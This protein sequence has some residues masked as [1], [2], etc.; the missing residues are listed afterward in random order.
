MIGSVNLLI[1]LAMG[2]NLMAL[3]SSRLPSVIRAMAVQGAAIG[4]LVRRFGERPVATI[5]P[6]DIEAMIIGELGKKK[7]GDT[8]R[9]AVAALSAV[10]RFL[11]QPAGHPEEP[12]HRRSAAQGREKTAAHG[13]RR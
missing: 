11:R 4:P 1:G 8:I 12:V 10:L 5:S 2:L 3:G 6:L 13:A 7:A 9:N